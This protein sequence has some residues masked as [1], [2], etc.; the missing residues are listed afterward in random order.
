MRQPVLYW[1]PAGGVQAGRRDWVTA[2]SPLTL[3]C[4]VNKQEQT[5]NVFSVFSCDFNSC[6]AHTKGAP[7]NIAST[8]PKLERTFR[9]SAPRHASSQSDAARLAG[10][11]SLARHSGV[12]SLLA[13]DSARRTPSV[14]RSVPYTG[15][16]GCCLQESSSPPA[17]T[18]SNPSS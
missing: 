18:P 17:S 12:R 11:L 1:P 9:S 3:V 4:Q 2:F 6:D 10:L 7:P 13:F 15:V 8:R 14:S 5:R 16:P